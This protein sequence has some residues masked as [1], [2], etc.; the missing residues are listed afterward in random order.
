MSRTGSHD[1]TKPVDCNPF[2][3]ILV[4]QTAYQT[5]LFH[6]WKWSL[7]VFLQSRVTPTAAAKRNLLS[8]KRITWG[9]LGVP[10]MMNTLKYHISYKVI[11]LY[12]SIMMILG[13]MLPARLLLVAIPCYCTFPHHYWQMTVIIV[14]RDHCYQIDWRYVSEQGHDRDSYQ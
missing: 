2:L 14:I 8:V 1:V 4:S 3:R 7:F 12:L 9:C 5:C 10:A 11:M 6:Q 13:G